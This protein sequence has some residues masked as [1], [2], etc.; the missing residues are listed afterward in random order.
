[1]TIP[2]EDDRRERERRLPERLGGVL[3]PFPTPF[4]ADGEVDA[5]ALCENVGRWNRTGVAGYVALGSTGERV[6]LDERERALV[7]ETARGC[8]PREM[9]FV[10]GV[11]EQGTR[12]TVEECRR[13]AARGADAVLVLTPH[14]Y[15]GAMTQGALASHFEAVADSSPAPVILYNIPQNTGVALAPETV[16]RLSAHRNVAGIKDSSGDVANFVEMIRLVGERAEEFALLTGHAGVFQA[17]LAAGAVGGILAAGCV[18]PRLCVEIYEA[19]RAG[20]GER[21]RELQRRLAPV[22]R[23]VTVRFGIGGLKYALDLLG[24]EGGAVRAPLASPDEEARREIAR[25]LEEAGGRADNVAAN[26]PARP[27]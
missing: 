19:A 27:A 16:A 3:L 26:V 2:V 20:D 15:K 1:M 21:A 12:G 11:G 7:V 4:G 22:A 8:V 14:F 13:A 10:V 9:A 17:S 23:A 24:F 25:L 5:R 6:H 18:M